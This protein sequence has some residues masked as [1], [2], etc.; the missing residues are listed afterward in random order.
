MTDNNK[1]QDA[2]ND[3]AKPKDESSHEAANAKDDYG[4]RM[5][6]KLKEREKMQHLRAEG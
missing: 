5:R 1:T 4:E 3:E 6:K 2:A